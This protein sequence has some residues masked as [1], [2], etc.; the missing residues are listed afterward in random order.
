MSLRAIGTRIA[1]KEKR[2]KLKF[3]NEE[4]RVLYNPLIV[5]CKN[6]PLNIKKLKRYCSRNLEQFFMQ[7]YLS[8][9]NI[10]FGLSLNQ[11]QKR[12]SL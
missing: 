6:I 2:A 7:N 4:E 9:K 5:N 3:F 1:A 10:N 12:K 11:T 8:V